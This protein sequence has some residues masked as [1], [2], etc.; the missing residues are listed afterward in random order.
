[1]AIS[2]SKIAIVLLV[3]GTLTVVFGTVLVFVGPIIVD[4]QIIKVG[5]VMNSLS[6]FE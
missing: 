2:R 6:T 5:L 4:D 1:M 3:A